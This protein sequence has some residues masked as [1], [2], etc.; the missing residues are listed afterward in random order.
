MEMV[1]KR[2]QHFKIVNLRSE[3]S[4]EVFRKSKR[5]FK[6]IFSQCSR[7]NSNSDRNYYKDSV[8]RIR[9]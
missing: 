1:P 5:C 3:K 9:K 8:V 2:D 6:Y 4:T 7:A